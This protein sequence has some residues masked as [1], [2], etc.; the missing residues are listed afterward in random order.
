M[1]KHARN[2][3][4]GVAATLMVSAYAESGVAPTKYRFDVSPQPLGKALNVFA[5]Q[6]G[7]N[8]YFDPSAIA[9]MESP[10]LNAELT[11]ED[12]LTRLLDGSRLK[13]VYVDEHTI[14]VMSENMMPKKTAHNSVAAWTKLAQA[15]VADAS[16]AVDAKESFASDGALALEE[17]IVSA[18][19]RIERIQ[20]VPV[21]VSVLDAQSLAENNQ[22]RLRDYLASVPSVYVAPSVQGLQTIV[23]RGITTG[24]N[25]PTVAVLVDGMP[26]THP[27]NGGGGKVIPEID[28]FDLDRIE[29]L[30]GPQGA[31]YGANAMGGL[32]NCVTTDPSIEAFRGRVQA[33]LSGIEN[34]EE[35]GYSVRGTANIPL[36]DSLATRVSA[37]SRRDPGYVD[38]VLTG[39]EAVN[40]VDSRGGRI[41]LLWKPSNNVSLRLAA[42]E[43]SMEGDGSSV[44]DPVFGD[45]AQSR[46]PGTGIYDR[47]TR[48]YSAVL[49][50]GLGSVDFTSITGY[51]ENDIL[52]IEDNSF[53]WGEP[54]GAMD[55]YVLD[56]TEADTTMLTQEF[57]AT[58]PIGNRL[59]LL[60]GLYYTDADADFLFTGPTLDPATFAPTGTNLYT[61]GNP[62]TYEELAVFTSLTVEV[63]DRF[64]VQFGVRR[65]DLKQTQA[66]SFSGVV[67]PG[68]P[69]KPRRSS[70]R[71]CLH[72]VGACRT[73]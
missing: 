31:L 57:R 37:Y 54:G 1:F 23:I 12:A 17:I 50:I 65:S 6:T 24:S 32:L 2:I 35:L 53:I 26:L 19:K 60:A 68:S 46:A 73:T 29:V 70:L 48:H 22:V 55:V 18:Q 38:N 36:G 3:A 59:Q 47:T 58:V 30:R 7:L 41:S 21:P 63:S 66:T 40:D 56:V 14:R 34:G 71:I 51:T 20:D 10:A 72:R 25:D 42:S 13:A 45:L 49:D 5:S 67:P 15:N 33:G 16:S 8:I 43:Q 9:G 64:D 27:T 39:Q 62:S 69:L 61:V 44:F 11:P 4:A 52:G 28:P